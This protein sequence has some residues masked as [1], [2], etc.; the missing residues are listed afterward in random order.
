[1][2]QG[3]VLGC[4]KGFEFLV[5]SGEVRVVGNRVEGVVVAVVS[6]VLPDVDCA[7]Q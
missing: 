5:E 7:G 4:Y 1:M 3:G 2:H 6:L